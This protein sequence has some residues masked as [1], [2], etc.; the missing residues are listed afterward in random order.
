MIWTE[1]P[2]LPTRRARWPARA[3]R[4]LV[5]FAIAAVAWALDL[6]LLA[7]VVAVA[8]VVTTVL[9]VASPRAEA[10]LGRGLAAV[11]RGAAAAV[12]FVLLGVVHLLIFLPL[13]LLL[14][15]AGRDPLQVRP[16][17]SDTG[18]RRHPDGVPATRT[19]ARDHEPVERSRPARVAVA[20]PRA[21]GVVVLL[22]LFDVGVGT[23]WNRVAGEAADDEREAAALSG[24][25]LLS[26][27][28]LADEPWAEPY[29]AELDAVEHRFEPFVLERIEDVDGD[30]ISSRDGIRTSFQPDDARAPEVWFFG[31]SALWGVGQRDEHTIPSVVSRL[32]EEAGRPIRVRNFGGLGYTS[33]QSA[34]RLEQELAV[35]PAPALVVVYDGADDVA[36]QVERPDDRPTHYDV[37]GVTTALTGRDSAREQAED[38]WESYRQHSVL[39][40]LADRVADVLG[41]Q[42]AW[43]ADDA[44]LARAADLHERSV[45]V[46]RH[47]ADRHDVPA[48]FAWQAAEG[49]E[50]D[51][52]AYRRLAAGGGPHDLSGVLD[53]RPDHFLDGVLTDEVGAEAVGAALWPLVDAELG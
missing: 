2:D 26:A 12:A 46:A 47:V 33:W 32:A 19:F 43:A 24:D 28:A 39:G 22:L 53:D 6:D 48:L 18:W 13:S 44:L 45:A 50:G 25:R 21:I 5:P 11:G 35:R 34:L 51:G 36:V 20:V 42:P 52:G 8:A 9:A 3:A 29:A 23:L 14:R 16:L 15:A 17:P 7:V 10:A 40:R 49:V 1:L 30:L 41:S 4:R 37:D 31:G 38:L 27:P